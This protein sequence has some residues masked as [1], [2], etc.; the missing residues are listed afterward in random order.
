MSTSSASCSRTRGRSPWARPDSIPSAATRRPEEQRRL[1]DAH[2]ALADEL[3]LPVVIHN[4][5]AD[6]ETASALASFGGTVVLHCFSSP[7]LVPVAVER[8]YY[9][10]F[11]G[12]ATYPNA[13]ALR[14]AAAALPRI[15]YSSRPTARTSLRSRCAAGRTNRRT[16]ST[17]STRWPPR[18]ARRRRA[19]GSDARQRDGRVRAP[20]TVAPKKSARAALPRRREHRG[21][22]RPARRAR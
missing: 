1:L 7:E 10:S 20:V 22:H 17:R 18:A 11:A 14:T 8:G 5:D 4:R 3:G 15:G 9:V 19:R 6:D 12:N 13:A 2:L 21:R 16:S